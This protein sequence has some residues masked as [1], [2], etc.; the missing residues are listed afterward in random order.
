MATI[1]IFSVVSLLLIVIGV[2]IRK[3]KCYWLI[4]GYNT[5]SK[6]EKASVDIEQA[7]KHIAR[8]CYLVALT[9]FLGAIF[10]NYFSIS[11][12]PFTIAIVIIIFGYV[13]YIQ[14]FDHNKKS[15]A[16]TVVI[17]VIALVTFSIMMIIFSSGK[18]PNKIRVT[19]TSIIIDGNFGAT[20]KKDDINEISIVENLPEVSLRVNGYSDGSSV[21]KGDFKLKNGD[22]VKLYIQSKSGPYI[23]IS[24]ITNDV[25][26]NYKDKN[27]TIQLLNNLK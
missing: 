22:K 9:L 1:I 6:E 4:S 5:S 8:M 14:K 3:Y 16:E 10:T 27:Q 17:I 2:S 11:I 12:F 26:I 7:A 18:E 25:Y 19:D 21:R 24:T 23:K 20:I 13:F 15:K